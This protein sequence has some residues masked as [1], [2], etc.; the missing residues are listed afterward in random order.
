MNNVEDEAHKLKTRL[1]AKGFLQK[2][3]ID[4]S[5][6]FSPVVRYDSLWLLLAIAA[7]EDLE[8]ASF[9]VSTAFLY[10]ELPEEIYMEIP[11]GV[12]C[13]WEIGKINRSTSADRGDQTTGEEN[14]RV[15][16]KL[17]KALYGLKQAP[18]CWNFRFKKFLES[19]NFQECN[20]D[21]CIFIGN[22]RGNSIHLG[23]FVD[24]GVIFSK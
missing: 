11:E 10:G 13:S 14:G 23:L 5:E 6:T 2:E 19:F 9:D 17:M 21:K 12:D 24:D 8:M 4:Y 15:V 7:E 1:C 20:A 18:R 22:Y 16:C 3:G